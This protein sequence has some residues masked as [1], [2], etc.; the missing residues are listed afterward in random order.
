MA[1]R[2]AKNLIFLSRSG[3]SSQEAKTFI[4]H[5]ERLQVKVTV[6]QGDVTKMI[7][8]QKAVEA[9]FGSIKGV[10]QAPLKLNVRNVLFPPLLIA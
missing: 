8:V 4:S 2:G 6:I 9:G 3:I 10:V 1:Q 7:D 5:F